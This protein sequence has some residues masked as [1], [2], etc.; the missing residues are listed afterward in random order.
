M[1]QSAFATKANV[2]IA[3]VNRYEQGWATP[4]LGTARK[5]AKALGLKVADIWDMDALKA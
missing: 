3:S 2:C 1:S 5:L 4:T